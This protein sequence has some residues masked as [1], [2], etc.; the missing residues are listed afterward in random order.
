MKI[1]RDTKPQNK[2][3]VPLATDGTNNLKVLLD[4]KKYD[5][6][7]TYTRYGPPVNNYYVDCPIY[8]GEISQE[9]LMEH[10]NYIEKIEKRNI[11]LYNS[12]IEDMNIL[13]SVNNDSIIENNANSMTIQ[14]LQ[15]Q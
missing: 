5:S 9:T 7:F 6:T 13:T 14:R 4:P 3:P 10:A 1:Y 8:Y 2:F 15:M 12:M 11:D